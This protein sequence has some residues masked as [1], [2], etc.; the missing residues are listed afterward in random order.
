MKKLNLLCIAFV[1]ALTSCSSDDDNSSA[2]VSGDIIGTWIGLDVEYSGRTVTEFLGQ[3]I[4]ADFVGEAYDVDYTLTFSEN[5]NEIV[6]SG[7]YSLEVTTTALGQVQVENI[8]NIEGLGNGTWNKD[9]DQLTIVSGG[10]TTVGTIV[11]LTSTSLIL[12][13]SEVQDISQD[14]LIIATT[15]NAIATFTKM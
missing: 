15:I 6:S 9:G 13:L 12:E 7:S 2:D 1:F 3:E 14:G 5:P 4:V 11:E 8:E 10:E